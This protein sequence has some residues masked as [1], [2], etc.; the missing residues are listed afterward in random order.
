M[1]SRRSGQSWIFSNYVWACFA[2]SLGFNSLLRREGVR[3]MAYEIPRHA[4]QSILLQRR[5]YYRHLVLLWN[6]ICDG[7]LLSTWM[8]ARTAD[9]SCGAFPCYLC[10]IKK[11]VSYYYNLLI[12]HTV[13]YAV[14]LNNIK[15]YI[16]FWMFGDMCIILIILYI[17]IAIDV[18]FMC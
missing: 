11:S 5:Q 6:H 14:L 1:T 16:W 15:L 7:I 18:L 17:P 8:K 12:V 9:D 13:G 3:W 2:G 4:G 10:V